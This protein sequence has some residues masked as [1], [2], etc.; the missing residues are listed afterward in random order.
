MLLCGSM[1][2]DEL[3]LLLALLMRF[4]VTQSLIWF[5]EHQ[6]KLTLL[7]SSWLLYILNGM[8]C[9]SCRLENSFRLSLSLARFLFSLFNSWK[10]LFL[11]RFFILFLYALNWCDTKVGGWEMSKNRILSID[12]GINFLRITPR[13]SK[14]G[15]SSAGCNVG[16]FRTS[17]SYSLPCFSFSP[18]LFL[19][20]CSKENSTLPSKSRWRIF[21]DLIFVLKISWF[22][23]A[24]RKNF[25]AFL[26]CL[27]AL[28]V[29]LT[30][31]QLDFYE[32]SWILTFLNVK[33]LN[34]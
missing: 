8:K 5:I 29:L 9:M 3:L 11:S 14:K 6:F 27:K 12:F 22:L 15:S 19:F 21:F 28:F 24:V 33:I 17:F 4:K 7:C 23:N 2:D 20:F 32:I 30:R 16:I 34:I 26:R 25:I 1:R 31:P 18:V 13:W 10:I